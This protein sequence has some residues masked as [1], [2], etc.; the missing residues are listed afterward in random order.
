MRTLVVQGIHVHV[1]SADLA[2]IT[3]LNAS[4]PC[5]PRQEKGCFAVAGPKRS[6]QVASALLD[7]LLACDELRLP[8]LEEN[9]DMLAGSSISARLLV[10]VLRQLQPYGLTPLARTLSF[11]AAPAASATRIE[12]SLSASASRSHDGSVVSSSVKSTTSFATQ[13]S[14]SNSFS[15][16]DDNTTATALLELVELLPQLRVLGWPVGAVNTASVSAETARQVVAL[17]RS[18]HAAEQGGEA[19]RAAEEGEGGDGGDGNGGDGNG[20]AVPPAQMLRLTCADGT[21]AF[22][23][24]A[25]AGRSSSTRLSL[26]LSGS[27]AAGSPKLRD[28]DLVLLCAALPGWRDSAA[29]AWRGQPLRELRLRFSGHSAASAP[30]LAAA[31]HGLR[32]EGALE[33]LDLSHLTMSTA[34]SEA[35]ARLAT[36]RELMLNGTHWPA[37]AIAWW[38][39]PPP[40]LEPSAAVS[41][42]S[43]PQLT[44]L[45]VRFLPAASAAAAASV[46]AYYLAPGRSPALRELRLD[47][48]PIGD[49]LSPGTALFPSAL[50]PSALSP[51]PAAVT[52]QTE[53]LAP[54]PALALQELWLNQAA[55][56]VEPSW[57]TC[58]LRLEA[59]HLQRNQL[60]TF[61]ASLDGLCR[62]RELRL[63]SNQLR[64]LTVPPL[65]ALETLDVGANSLGDAMLPLVEKLRPTYSWLQGPVLTGDVETPGLLPSLRELCLDANKLPRA[66]GEALARGLDGDTRFL[67]HLRKLDLAK[68][69]ELAPCHEALRS[70][71]HDRP[72]LSLLV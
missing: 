21:D 33:V 17:L 61:G 29:C 57:L 68:N 3:H 1:A 43:M 38:Q 11:S 6:S 18:R 54:V 30:E 5:T 22:T 39:P 40:P 70:A 41:A 20:T 16:S 34:V 66:V 49:A 71:A 72:Q 31:L 55:L 64:A 52:Q 27:A 58:C 42:S 7:A 4:V 47:G 15:E 65:P 12:A 9:E 28:A 8:L 62:L 69:L 45:H 63:R 56:A 44:T 26:H 23:E 13:A 59:L 32:K 35:V 19:G 37:D 67:K 46:G 48:N 36:L 10:D 2:A 50:S 24:A 60:T 14:Q 25:V 51:S 53:P